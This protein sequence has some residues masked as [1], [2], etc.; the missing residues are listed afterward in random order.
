MVVVEPSLVGPAASGTPR[1]RR[2]WRR[3][4]VLG[5]G[6]VLALVIPGWLVADA[7][8]SVDGVW[9]PE[10]IAAYAQFTDA[11]ESEPAGTALLL[12]SSGNWEVFDTYQDLALGVDGRSY[13]QIASARVKTAA[14]ASR[15][16]FLAPDGASVLIS[17]PASDGRPLTTVDLR[18]GATRDIPIAAGAGVMALA[19]SPDL[20]TVAL[21]VAGPGPDPNLSYIRAGTLTLLD[22]R[23]GTLTPLPGLGDSVVAAAWSPD[24]RELA[25][26]AIVA[27]DVSRATVTTRAVV[28]DA[29]GS[30]RRE[31]PIPTGLGLLQYVAWSPDGRWIAMASYTNQGYPAEW[32][33]PDGSGRRDLV[34]VDAT[35]DGRTGPAVTVG[36]TVLGWLGP[37]RLLQLEYTK[38]FDRGVVLSE[39]SLADGQARRLAAFESSHAC[40]HFLMPC[41]TEFTMYAATGLLPQMKV[42]SASWW[43]DRGPTRLRLLLS[44]VAVVSWLIGRLVL[45]WVRRRAASR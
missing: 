25:V 16:T 38:G 19:W 29:T 45:R 30:L 42:R 7:G 26:Q 13:R 32:Q 23:T 3:L 9:L 33:N 43:L 20:R 31:L 22:L 8:R 27:N 37:D 36:P 12:Y 39:L 15:H 11:A 28:V 2:R 41:R 44:A 24:S 34:L 4:A 1:P 10:S 17:D 40:E 21:A 18:T 6:L 35:G 5:V 14:G